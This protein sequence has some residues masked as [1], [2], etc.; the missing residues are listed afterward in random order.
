MGNP[1]T[2]SSVIIS[3]GYYSEPQPP[4]MSTASSADASLDSLD[5]EL[6]RH[7]DFK[8]LQPNPRTEM[9]LN[10]LNSESCEYVWS[11]QMAQPVIEE[12]TSSDS[13]SQLTEVKVQHL[14]RT[15]KEPGHDFRKIP[16]QQRMRRKNL[17][18]QINALLDDEDPAA[19]GYLPQTIVG[20]PDVDVSTGQ[21][22]Y[23]GCTMGRQN[24]RKYR[25]RGGV[26]KPFEDARNKKA[27]TLPPPRRLKRIGE[28]R[29]DVHIMQAI[30]EP[31]VEA[32]SRRSCMT[33]WLSVLGLGPR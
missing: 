6:F 16:M 21:F 25:D 4:T 26:Y 10:Q 27:N 14:V 24:R 5:E 15:H 28:Q 29:P 31:A 22:C 1:E 17:Q 18:R 32:S 12:E 3:S 2:A 23:S 19:R 11:A 9:I 30:H 13:S 8:N 20:Y 7:L 33:S